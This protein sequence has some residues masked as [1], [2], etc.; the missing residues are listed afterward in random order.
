MSKK[1]PGFT[2]KHSSAPTLPESGV[3]ITDFVAY[4]PGHNYVFL[5]CRETWPGASI[6]ARLPLQ[7]LTDANG[8]P[9]TRAAR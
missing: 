9:L 4:M 3:N 6:D 2:V 8:Q 7:V 1:K 5:P